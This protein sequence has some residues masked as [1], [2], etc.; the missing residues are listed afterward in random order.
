VAIRTALDTPP[1]TLFNPT[2]R[3]PNEARAHAATVPPWLGKSDR[4]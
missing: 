3:A 1:D 4:A 2:I